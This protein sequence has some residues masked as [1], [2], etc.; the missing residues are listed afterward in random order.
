M[1]NCSG[2]RRS[3]VSLIPIGSGRPIHSPVVSLT[4]RSSIHSGF[5]YA[6]AQRTFGVIHVSS[7]RDTWSLLRFDDLEPVH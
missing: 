2:K 1:C 7:A 6:T 4:H 3:R 5:M